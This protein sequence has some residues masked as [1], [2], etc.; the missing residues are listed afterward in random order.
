MAEYVAGVCNIGPSE[1]ARRKIAGWVGVAASA[2]FLLLFILFHT[3]PIFRL[4]IFLPASLAASG[5]LQAYFHFCAGFGFKGVYNLM[6]RAGQ[7][8]TVEQEAFRKK[9]R[10]KAQ[11]IMLFSVL[12]GLAIAILIYF[13]P[14]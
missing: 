8:E 12:I 3:A 9:D 14:L 4:F 6:K 11:Q 2:V 7:T 10:Q 5:F 1:I 13:L